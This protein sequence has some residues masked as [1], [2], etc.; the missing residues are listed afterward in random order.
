MKLADKYRALIGAGF[1]T[2][3]SIASA[4]EITLTTRTY[5]KPIGYD[6]SYYVVY[7]GRSM[8]GQLKGPWADFVKTATVSHGGITAT[9]SN[10][11]S[12][13][14]NSTMDVVFR[15]GA[16]V[17]MDSQTRY[18]TVDVAPTFQPRYTRDIKPHIWIIAAPALTG[19]SVPKADYYQTVDVVLTGTNLQGANVATATARV[20]ATY[21][22]AGYA[23]EAPQI[24]NGVAI[25]ASIVGTPTKTQ[26]IVRLSLPQKLTAITAD[27]KLTGSNANVCSPFGAGPGA[28]PPPIVSRRVTMA[29][30]GP[31]IPPKVQS[32]DV[33]NA[34][35]GQNVDFTIT[36]DKPVPNTPT[37]RPAETSTSRISGGTSLLPY[38]S[39]IV[40]FK[41]SPSSV[42]STVSGDVAYNANG[43][44]QAIVKI[45][46]KVAH[47]K[48][49]ALSLPPGSVNVGTVYIQ[50]WIG[51]NTKNQPPIFFQ[52]EFTIAQ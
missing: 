36:L 21:P 47:F 35:V 1:L 32:I 39:M 49:R 10:P 3:A 6:W 51:D 5:C 29:V 28:D 40:W 42:F 18:V 50:T 13:W 19:Y 43:F 26:A 37:V 44:S 23:S 7:A 52:K 38:G 2:A 22:V 9:L 11:Q 41:I 24:S 46:E 12:N 20:D 31:P 27:I 33:L 34:R 16:D 14:S 45:G 8:K 25:P 4:Q 30:P 15:V 17:D 48:L